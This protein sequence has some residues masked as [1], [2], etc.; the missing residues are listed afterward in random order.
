MFC[1]LLIIGDEWLN[2]SINQSIMDFR[3]A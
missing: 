1:I 2:Q 3:V